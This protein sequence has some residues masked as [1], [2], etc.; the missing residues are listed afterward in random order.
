MEDQLEGS[1]PVGSGRAMV[2]VWAKR[3]WFHWNPVLFCFETWNVL[4]GQLLPTDG[5]T[6]R[7]DVGTLSGLTHD[8]Q[9]SAPSIKEIPLPSG[10]GNHE[11]E[12]E[13]LYEPEGVE[14]TKET[15]SSGHKRA[16]PHMNSETGSMPRACPGSNQMGSQ[17]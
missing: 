14:D 12:V 15:V 11:E 5:N 2:S 9:G 16:D 13:R 4:S 7:T 8:S 3:V 1:Q 10:L 6:E 17:L